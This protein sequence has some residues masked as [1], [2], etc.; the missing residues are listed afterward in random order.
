MTS[1]PVS[2]FIA[3][4]SERSPLLA[5]FVKLAR[6]GADGPPTKGLDHVYD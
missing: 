2:A 4:S 3:A 5:I 1:L 6:R